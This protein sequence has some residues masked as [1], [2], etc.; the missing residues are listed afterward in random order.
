MIPIKLLIGYFDPR[1]IGLDCIVSVFADCVGQSVPLGEVS[2]CC[3]WT[4]ADAASYRRM[5]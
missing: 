2:L 4:A 1:D 5:R 3:P